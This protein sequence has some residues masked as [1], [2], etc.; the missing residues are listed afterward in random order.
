VAGFLAELGL[1][2]RGFGFLSAGFF[3]VGDIVKLSFIYRSIIQYSKYNLQ[4]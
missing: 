3:T 4:K 2:V 1:L